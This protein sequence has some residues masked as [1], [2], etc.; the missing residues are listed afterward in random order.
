MKLR[1]NIHWVT[2]NP[3]YT[4]K[5]LL[6]YGFTIPDN[7]DDTVVLKFTPPLS[8][9]QK[10]VRRMQVSEADDKGIYYLHSTNRYPPEQLIQLF[11]ILV[12]IPREYQILQNC[13]TSE[14]VT[15]RNELASKLQLLNALEAKSA[16]IY[17]S[18]REL[19][20]E[21]GNKTHE[22]ILTYRNEQLEIL[23]SVIAQLEAEIAAYQR[24]PEAIT[25]PRL[26]AQDKTFRDAIEVCFGDLE[27]IRQEGLEDRVFVLGLCWKYLQSP[28]KSAFNNSASPLSRTIQNESS[29]SSHSNKTLAPSTRWPRF[30]TKM[31]DFYL[32]PINADPGDVTETGVTEGAQEEALSL[33]EDL[34]PAAADAAPEVF[35]NH[36]QGPG[37]WNAELIRDVTR[38]YQWEGI[39]VEGE[40]LLFID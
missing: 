35:G 17:R 29:S 12:A 30:F 34:F 14:V 39:E 24:K 22:Y 8:G 28:V 4:Y 1:V 32:N 40:Y 18:E 25:L 16:R 3:T 27:T 31:W 38:F 26:L 10:K 37:G 21:N 19:V 36:L 6:S 23:S 13:P 11:H 5:V 15:L 20:A 33:F 7:P 9:A 2:S